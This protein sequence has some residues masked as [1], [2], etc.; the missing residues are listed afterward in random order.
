MRAAPEHKE[1]IMTKKEVYKLI[2]KH[3]GIPEQA[4]EDYI[5]IYDEEYKRLKSLGIKNHITELYEYK[6]PFWHFKK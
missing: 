3:I 4:L 5:N 6:G 1:S 2:E